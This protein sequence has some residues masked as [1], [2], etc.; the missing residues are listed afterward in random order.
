MS[1]FSYGIDKLVGVWIDCSQD[2]AD[3]LNRAIVSKAE[4][5]GYKLLKHP[6]QTVEDWEYESYDA[7]DYL[8]SICPYGY[9]FEID[10][11]CLILCEEDE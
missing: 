5:Y 7:F 10:N 1:D 3:N 8:S 6:P 11:N 4:M 2:S 9:W